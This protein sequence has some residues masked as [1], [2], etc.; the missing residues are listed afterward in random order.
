MESCLRVKH[1]E[2]SRGNRID[3]YSQNVYFINQLLRHLPDEV[4]DT[5]AELADFSIG[6]AALDDHG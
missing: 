2:D 4:A 5:G 3:S 1:F 6:K